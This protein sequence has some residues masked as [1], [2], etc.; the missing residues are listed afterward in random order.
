M[1]SVPSPLGKYATRPRLFR[2]RPGPFQAADV[3]NGAFG[4]FADAKTL[5]MDNTYLVGRDLA[6][7]LGNSTLFRGRTHSCKCVVEPGI[8]SQQLFRTSAA[9]PDAVVM[10]EKAARTCSG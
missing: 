3:S 5:V 7:S 9:L 10:G 8:W 2:N 1:R 6:H 4:Q